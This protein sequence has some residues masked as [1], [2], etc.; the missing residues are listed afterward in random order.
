MRI[1]LPHDLL[2]PGTHLKMA[3]DQLQKFHP[4][5]KVRREFSGNYFIQPWVQ[6]SMPPSGFHQM[7]KVQK[8][9][10]RIRWTDGASENS[11]W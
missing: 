9:G 10:L 1:T 8:V 11:V 6:L 7:T 4:D 2:D 3:L 5:V